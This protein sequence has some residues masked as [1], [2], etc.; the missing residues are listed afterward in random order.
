MKR[1]VRLY[2]ND[3]ITSIEKI[4]EYVKDTGKEGFLNYRG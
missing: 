3:I 1:D 4:Q 2:L